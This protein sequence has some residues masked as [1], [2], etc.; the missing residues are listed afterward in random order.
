MKARSLV[1]AAV[2]AVL[3]A[4]G[5]AGADDLAGR[6]AIG[7]QVGTQSDVAGQVLKGSKGTLLGQSATVDA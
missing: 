6:I 1:T 4:A 3:L 2:L 7:V 5:S